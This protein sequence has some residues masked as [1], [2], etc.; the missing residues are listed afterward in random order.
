MELRMCKCLLK[1]LKEVCGKMKSDQHYI[2]TDDFYISVIET[3]QP[4]IPPIPVHN[5]MNTGILSLLKI[6]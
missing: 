6:F 4:P 1:K 3:K 2:F 5:V